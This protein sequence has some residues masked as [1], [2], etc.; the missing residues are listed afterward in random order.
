MNQHKPRI[1]N[2]LPVLCPHDESL[3]DRI[4]Y[5]DGQFSAVDPDDT[6][7]TNLIEFLGWNDPT[8][9]DYRR[10]HISRMQ[11]DRNVLFDNNEDFVHHM[12]NHPY[13]LSFITALEAEL[14]F[15]LI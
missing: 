11:D 4:Q 5:E 13:N 10:K 1:Q 7:A 9:A 12:R 8:L 15:T 6:E 3:R 14:G 2:Y